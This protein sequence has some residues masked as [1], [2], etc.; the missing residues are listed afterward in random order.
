MYESGFESPQLLVS[1]FLPEHAKPLESHLRGGG[2]PPS[3]LV[4]LLSESVCYARCFNLVLVWCLYCP[5]G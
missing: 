3:A 1:S 5:L 4:V 2:M